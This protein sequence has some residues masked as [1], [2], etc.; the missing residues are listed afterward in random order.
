[1]HHVGHLPSGGTRVK[2]NLRY[3]EGSDIWVPRD[4][5]AYQVMISRLDDIT[6][7]HDVPEGCNLYIEGRWL[8]YSEKNRIKQSCI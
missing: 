3:T 4:Q 6:K 7:R 1:M 5:K 8:S 2:D